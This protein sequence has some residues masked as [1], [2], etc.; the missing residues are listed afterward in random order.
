[1]MKNQIIEQ[2]RNRSEKIYSNGKLLD[3][4]LYGDIYQKSKR[5]VPPPQ[6]YEN[7][8]NQVQNFLYKRALYGLNIYD[9]KEI[10]EMPRDIKNKI[11][12]VCKRANKEITLLKQSIIIERSN[13][14]L[15]LFDRSPLAQDILNDSFVDPG[16]HNKF[17]FSDLG[18]KKEDV[19]ARLHDTGVLPKNF[20]EINAR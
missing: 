3:Y 6:R 18:I 20:Y 4:K 12:K 17:N 16:L 13:E 1:M 2:I 8:Y 7:S 5:R 19:I 15:A 14:I 11:I 10:R 9:D